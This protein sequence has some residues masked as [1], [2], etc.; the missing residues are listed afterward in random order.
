[1]RAPKK[2]AQSYAL[3]YAMAKAKNKKALAHKWAECMTA[4]LH[5]QNS[6]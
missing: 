6:H 2:F 4:A 3:A 1:M 5:K